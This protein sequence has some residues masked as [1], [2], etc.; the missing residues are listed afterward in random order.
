MATITYSTAASSSIRPWY[1]AI[2][3]SSSST[4]VWSD[5]TYE[6]TFTGSFTFRAGKVIGG[7]LLSY[8]Q[9][10]SGNT[11]V[12]VT[13][14]NLAGFTLQG[15]WDSADH[16]GL[17]KSIFAGKDTV[18]GT[19]GN[20][21]LIGFGGGEDTINGGAGDD[22]ITGG[23]V[24][25]NLNGGDG[26]DTILGGGGT[27]DTI[28]GGA[29]N[30]QMTAGDYSILNG[31]TGDDTYILKSSV[32]H[33]VEIAGEGTDEIQSSFTQVMGANVE[34]LTL[35]G[36]ANIAGFGNASNNLM[37][38]NAAN[39]NLSGGAGN[40]TVMGGLGADTVSG[41]TG[42]DTLNGGAGK[43]VF[44]FDSTPNAATNLDL[45]EDFV[46]TSTATDRIALD[47]DIFTAFQTTGLLKA[48]QFYNLPDGAPGVNYRI[49]Y[50]PAS[51]VL[52]YDADG[53]AGA[54]VGGVLVNAAPIQIAVVGAVT[55]AA[56]TYKDFFIVK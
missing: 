21:T 34:N 42:A 33:A 49:I 41:G 16:T 2:T 47:R 38:G 15:F 55:H 18:T 9:T 17:L 26:N 10:I 40:D 23:S 13:G 53:S 25:D 4:I 48:S 19:A 1:G 31:G 30:D 51:G 20:D 32:A 46:H 39:N 24:S 22:S 54:F 44:L 5:G 36:T 6:T 29:G 7:T 11:Y 56:L 27:V 8:T 3:S 35:T 45:L 52:S 50:D 28:N 43:D 14:L 12:S 37:T